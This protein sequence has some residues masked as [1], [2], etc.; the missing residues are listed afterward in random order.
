M[1]P[2]TN[3][4]G[5]RARTEIVDYLRQTWSDQSIRAYL[6]HRDIDQYDRPERQAGPDGAAFLDRVPLSAWHQGMTLWHVSEPSE[7]TAWVTHVRPE[8]GVPAWLARVLT[9]GGEGTVRREADSPGPAGLMVQIP[10]VDWFALAREHEDVELSAPWEPPTL[11]NIEQAWQLL[12]GAARV[13]EVHVAPHLDTPGQWALEVGM[14]AAAGLS[15]ETVQRVSTLL[16][17]RDGGERVAMF[18][19]VV[20]VLTRDGAAPLSSWAL[21]E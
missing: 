18:P 12:D 4:D 14:L 19:P 17:A 5:V 9:K 13:M 15:P 16:A 7:T 20:G 1:K 11:D 8:H 10:G 21:Y 6:A 2:Q 3:L